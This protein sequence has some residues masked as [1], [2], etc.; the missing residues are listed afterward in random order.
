MMTIIYFIMHQWTLL[1]WGIPI[2]IGC[3]YLRQLI[4]WK[5]TL[6]VI[7]LG[8]GFIIYLLGKKIERDNQAKYV[9]D[10]LEKREVAYEKI[11]NRNTSASDAAD[12]LRRGSF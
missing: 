9:H 11:D 8:G 6:P 7:A 2:G 10:I 12:R 5:P 4:G 1:I 3:L